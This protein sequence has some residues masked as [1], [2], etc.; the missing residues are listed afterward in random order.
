MAFSSIKDLK[1]QH[2]PAQLHDEAEC[3]EK[4]AALGFLPR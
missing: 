1:A 4:A 2:L 3:E